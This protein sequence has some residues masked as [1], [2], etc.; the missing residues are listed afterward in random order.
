MSIY[1]FG[2]AA[3][4]A[5]TILIYGI[6]CM[7][8]NK[9]YC[10]SVGTKITGVLIMILVPACP[11]IIVA[12]A[13]NK[14]YDFALAAASLLCCV[15]ALPL[16]FAI[17]P[18]DQYPR[19]IVLTNPSSCERPYKDVTIEVN[20]IKYTLTRS[21]MSMAHAEYIMD[22]YIDELFTNFPDI[23]KEEVRGI[24]ERAYDIYSE[25][26]GDTEYEALEKAVKEFDKAE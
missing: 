20:G 23:P 16:I 25:G 26:E 6:V 24:A 18:K 14:N 8:R 13:G 12:M 21:E 5:L 19:Q 1:R 15:I 10:H 3:I 2:L 11:F 9:E 22:F 4:C 17:K 7:I